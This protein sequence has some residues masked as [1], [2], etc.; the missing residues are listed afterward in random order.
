MVYVPQIELCYCSVGEGARLFRQRRVARA[1]TVAHAPG[2][3][4]LSND[5]RWRSGQDASLAQGINTCTT[6][7]GSGRLSSKDIAIPYNNRGFARLVKGD[8][9]RAIADTYRCAPP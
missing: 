4:Q 2:S 7:I 5:L 1:M 9:E 6:L 8:H 3:A